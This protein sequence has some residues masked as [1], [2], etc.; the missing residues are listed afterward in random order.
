M[1]RQ[2]AYCKYSYFRM[3][4]PELYGLRHP[5][6]FKFHIPAYA[7]VQALFLC[8]LRLSGTHRLDLSAPFCE[9]LT[10]SHEHLKIFYFL[11]GILCRPLRPTLP[12]RHRFKF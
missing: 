3:L 12:K 7:L 1:F 2:L 4:L 8:L 6:L 9:L 11:F 10:T 5:N